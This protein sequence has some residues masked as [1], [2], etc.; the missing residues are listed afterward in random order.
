ME[1]IIKLPP[2][3]AEL[4][5]IVQGRN[6][7]KDGRDYYRKYIWS[8]CA[9]CGKERW[10]ALVKGKPRNTRCLSCRFRLNTKEKNP[11]WKGGKIKDDRGYIYLKLYEDNPY[12]SMAHISGRYL[13]EHRLVMAQSLGRCLK[14]DEIVHHKN[15]DKSDNRLENLEL[16]TKGK[17]IVEHGKG[18]SDGYA[19]GL[20]DGKDKQ[21]EALRKEIKLLQWQIKEVRQH[22]NITKV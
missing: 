10:V 14:K 2:V 3:R 18:Y 7:G 8:A 15:G 19:K 6:I 17:H 12:Y 9:G 20:T 11:Y 1:E 5:A 4:G 21:I 13:Q 16:M 22:G